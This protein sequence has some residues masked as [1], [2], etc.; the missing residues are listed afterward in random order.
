MFQIFETTRVVAVVAR[1]PSSLAQPAKCVAS[2]Q[3]R[4]GPQ[5]ERCGAR[6]RTLQPWHNRYRNFCDMRKGSLGCGRVEGS[7]DRRSEKF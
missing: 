5:V 7:T 1:T 2:W 3:A 6:A 4:V